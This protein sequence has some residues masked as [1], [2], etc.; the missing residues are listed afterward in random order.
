VRF[1]GATYLNGPVW[2]LETATV[3]WKE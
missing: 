2:R 3:Q 1:T